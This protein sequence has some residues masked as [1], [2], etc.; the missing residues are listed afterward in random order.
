MAEGLDPVEFLRLSREKSRPGRRRRRRKQERRRLGLVASEASQGSG[1]GGKKARR[2]EVLE[3][4]NAFMAIIRIN[5]FHARNGPIT[6][7]FHARTESFIRSCAT[8]NAKGK[9]GILGALSCVFM[10]S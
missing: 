3:V 10:A 5:G 2:K 7:D 4:S 6:V 1:Y 9:W 8:Y